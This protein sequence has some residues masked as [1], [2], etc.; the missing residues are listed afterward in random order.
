MMHSLVVV[1]CSLGVAT[2]LQDVPLGMCFDCEVTCIKDCSAKFEKEVM[3]EDMASLLQIIKK[4][5]TSNLRAKTAVAN[6]EVQKM[7][8]ASEQLVKEYSSKFHLEGKRSCGT[9]SEKE[10]GCGIAKQCVDSIGNEFA[11]LEKMDW[12]KSAEREVD[13]GMDVIDNRGHKAWTDVSA[14]EVTIADFP[15]AH[16]DSNPHLRS[17]ASVSKESLDGLENAHM[18]SINNNGHLGQIQVDSSL[19][20]APSAPNPYPL[21]PVK[22]G[23]FSKGGHTLTQCMTYCFAAT[24]GCAGQGVVD[25]SSIPKKTKEAA[26]HGFY[27]DTPPSWKYKPAT[28][29]QCGA[30]VKKI[31]KGL[32]ID[33][34]PGVG[35]VV[36]VCSME[37]FK[38]KAGASGALGLT[39]PAEDKEKCDCGVNRLDCHEPDFG[40]SWNPLGYCEFKA[41]K[42]TRCYHRYQTDPTR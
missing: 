42:H 34:Y 4:T 10:K 3:A 36:E 24:C 14:Q 18:S 8:K 23:I 30:G 29:E 27:T 33:Y 39:D 11:N 37:Y 35:G 6:P 41:L 26:Q 13:H 38:N 20:P 19:A 12:E 17:V 40:C 21:H 28:K 32:Y 2:G 22:L 7:C 15:K 25:I 9:A 5:N 31:I 1:L 16:I